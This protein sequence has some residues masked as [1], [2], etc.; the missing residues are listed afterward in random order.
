MD[1]F[2]TTYEIEFPYPRKAS[3][4]DVSLLGDVLAAMLAQEALHM[5]SD[6]EPSV[7]RLGLAEGLSRHVL[8]ARRARY[9]LLQWV[10]FTAAIPPS[11]QPSRR[12]TPK[13]E[14]AGAQEDADTVE[15]HPG[16]WSHAASPSPSGPRSAGSPR[17]ISSS[18]A[19]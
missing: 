2:L 5:S 16:L 19:D 8:S 11:R 9:A 4:W 6:G 13:P 15:E 1:E 7:I 17:S 18:G 10:R 3:D 12:V 14:V